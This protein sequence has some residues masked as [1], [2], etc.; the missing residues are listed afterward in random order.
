MTI[1]QLL[2]EEIKKGTFISY[3]YHNNR[4]LFTAPE[5]LCKAIADVLEVQIL[6]DVQILDS[7]LTA[8]ALAF[9]VL[10]QLTLYSS[11]KVDVQEAYLDQALTIWANRANTI[12]S[13]NLLFKNKEQKENDNNFTC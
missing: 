6:A 4:G 5:A 9:V 12:H 3:L 1:E 2:R 13:F 7:S 11:D 8:K 10:D